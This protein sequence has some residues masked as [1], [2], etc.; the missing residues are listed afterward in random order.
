MYFSRFSLT[1]K[2]RETDLQNLL[3]EDGLLNDEVI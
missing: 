3:G 1:F 2:I